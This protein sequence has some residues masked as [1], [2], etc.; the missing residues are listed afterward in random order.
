[1]YMVVVVLGTMMF[2]M[3]NWEFINKHVEFYYVFSFL[4]PMAG[5][6]IGL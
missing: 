5:L 1:M 6:N 3:G 2:F 4:V